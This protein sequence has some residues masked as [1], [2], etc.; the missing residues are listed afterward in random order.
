MGQKLN[1]QTDVY[2]LHLFEGFKFVLISSYSRMGP[3]NRIYGFVF[4]VRQLSPVFEFSY[5]Q[6]LT[7]GPKVIGMVYTMEIRGVFH[8]LKKVQQ[9]SNGLIKCIHI[10]LKKAFFE[11]EI[12]NK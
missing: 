4:P 8:A 5:V 12:I 7:L 2:I 6:F 3:F 9:G 11:K 1:L 10:I